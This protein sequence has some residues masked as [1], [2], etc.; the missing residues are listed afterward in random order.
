MSSAPDAAPAKQMHPLLRMFVGVCGLIAVIGG[1][2]K[3]TAGVN[4]ILDARQDPMVRELLAASDQQIEVANQL[5]QEVTP[6]FQSLLVDVDNLGLDTVRKDKAELAKQCQQAFTN[7]ALQARQAA[8][9]LLESEQHRVNERFKP[10][11]ETKAQAYEKFAVACDK[12]AEIVR[13]VIDPAIVKI[14]DLLP[15]LNALAARA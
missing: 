11:L 14:D 15:R 10:Y 7:A 4:E 12:N 5:V 8:A 1:V 3:M 13:L 9:K 6:K 2:L